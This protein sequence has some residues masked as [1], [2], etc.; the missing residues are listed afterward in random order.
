MADY[1]PQG[2]MVTINGVEC[3]VSWPAG[4]KTAVIVFQDIFGIHTG[5]HKQFCDM[6]AERGYGAVAPDFT[7][8]DPI[9]TNPPKYGCSCW[10]FWSFVCGLLSGRTR[11]RQMELSW[12]NSMENIVLHCVVPWLE[13]KGVTTKVASVGFCFGAYGAMQCGRFPEIFSCSASFHP[14]TENF[15]KSTQEDDLVLCRA[16]RVPQL[17]V[18]TSMESARWKPNGEAHKACE[19]TGMVTT[20]LLEEKQKHGF[21]MRGDTSDTETLAAVRKYL[22]LMFEFF[23]ANTK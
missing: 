14:S 15:C 12:A 10:C 22:D 17:V 11:R 5:R 19:E 23:E 3:F 21:M 9:V 2:K 18:A 16:V 4:A 6:L 20:W 8:T 13:Q 1:E 7:G